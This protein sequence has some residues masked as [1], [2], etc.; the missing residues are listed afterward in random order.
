M[1]KKKPEKKSQKTSTIKNNT[2]VQW[3][4]KMYLIVRA[5]ISRLMSRRPH[6]SF[7]LTKRR[8]Y[9]RS[10]K[11]PGY[12]AFTVTVAKVLWKNRKLFGGLVIVYVL[13][14][15]VISG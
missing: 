3:F 1:A 2:V 4:M 5:R 11:L 15:I 14:T 8:D 7:L 10:F 9:K 12:W 13:A 6:R